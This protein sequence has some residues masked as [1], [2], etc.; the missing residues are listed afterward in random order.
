MRCHQCQTEFAVGAA[1]CFNCGTPV[2][3]N[4]T[5]T[6]SE[7]FF[8]DKLPEELIYQ[9]YSA[10]TQAPSRPAAL[11]LTGTDYGAAVLPTPPPPVMPVP[12]V[13][14]APPIPASVTPPS[15]PP[16]RVP[17]EQASPLPPAQS[18]TR[19]KKW[20]I[21]G[22][23]IA[24]VCLVVCGGSGL[25]AFSL[26][27]QGNSSGANTQQ[28]Q[29]DPQALYTQITSKSPTYIDNLDGTGVG[30]W[31]P[32][33]DA[34]N[35]CHYE[36]SSYHVRVSQSG[37]TFGCNTATLYYDIALQV[38]VMIQQGDRA[39]V[40]FR[41]SRDGVDNTRYIFAFDSKGNSELQSYDISNTQT[42]PRS[43]LANK[44]FKTG[45]GQKN[46]A[47]LIVQ[48]STVYCYVNGTFLFSYANLAANSGDISLAAE[49]QVKPTEVSYSHARIWLL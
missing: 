18:R 39:D 30:R 38:E 25:L 29:D 33:G 26:L 5:A 21:I 6:P 47:M 16:Y 19:G 14:V 11:P 24:L 44:A 17:G 12:P 10:P 9:E 37:S 8:Y 32:Q 34:A 15:Y 1:F 46:I 27:Q 20:M 36:G 2:D 35:G 13:P 40:V 7:R 4:V 41:A 22:G 3:E 31:N 28:N 43:E 45:L 49:S 23:V 48:G 42:R